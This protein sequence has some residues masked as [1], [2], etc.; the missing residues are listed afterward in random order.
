MIV[1]KDPHKCA[2]CKFCKSLVMCPEGNVKRAL[3]T[4]SCIGCGA[5]IIACPNEALS[6]MKYE[7]PE[8]KVFVNNREVMASGTV[9]NATEKAGIEINKFPD[10]TGEGNEQIFMPCECGGCWACTVKVDG[11]TALSCITP[12]YDGMKITTQ[13]ND[14]DKIPMRVVSGFGPH[15][16]GGVGTP[17]WLKSQGEAIEIAAFT[18]GCNLRCPQCQNYEMA[19]TGGSHLLEAPEA[20]KILLGLKEAYKVNTIAISGGESTLNRDWLIKLFQSIR[21]WDAKVNLHLDTNGTILTPDY[22]DDL[23][24][25][26]MTQLG[27]DLKALEISTFQDITGLKDKKLAA[28]YL[29]TSWNALAYVVDNYLEEVFMGIGIPYNQDLI[30]EK[31]LLDMGHKIY[32]IKPDLQIC[33]LDYRPEFRRKDLNR[34]S[35]Q[36]M[37]HLKEIFDNIGLETVIVQTE[38]GHFGP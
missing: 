29:E 22:I 23:V 35:A 7:L 12:L 16:V 37:I 1:K 2:D 3:E 9:K 17:Y 31:E 13:I 19:F 21:G 4:S 5:C 32:G 34:P 6:L 20:G 26:G 25:A 36:E 30:S 18:H 10:Y 14:K 11:K 38:K 8:K 24:Q 15:S 27:V 33:I 28:K